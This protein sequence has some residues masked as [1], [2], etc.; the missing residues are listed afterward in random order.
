MLELCSFN[1]D[2]A[3]LLVL[4]KCIKKL[5]Y[6]QQFF[7]LTVVYL[8]FPFVMI[9]LF[10]SYFRTNSA[11]KFPNGFYFTEKYEQFEH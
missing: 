8:D 1:N 7:S 3:L 4:V 11:A 9:V 10:L 5:E 6:F 2:A